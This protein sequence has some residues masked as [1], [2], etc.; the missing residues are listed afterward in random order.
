MD[1]GWTEKNFCGRGA[2]LVLNDVAKGA[3]GRAGIPLVVQSL[4]QNEHPQN[5]VEPARKDG[6]AQGGDLVH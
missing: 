5:E 1:A 6:G 2:R 4:Q 3:A